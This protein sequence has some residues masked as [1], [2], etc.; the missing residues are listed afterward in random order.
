[1]HVHGLLLPLLKK[2]L[3]RR[4]LV[5]LRNVAFYF[6]FRNLSWSVE[7]SSSLFDFLFF[8]TKWKEKKK[9]WWVFSFDAKGMAVSCPSLESCFLLKNASVSSDN[10]F[11][12]VLSVQ[13]LKEKLSECKGHWLKSKGIFYYYFTTLSSRKM[14]LFL[15]ISGIRIVC[16]H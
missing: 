12:P 6:V 15:L 1:M 16:K 11:L 4:S 14:W 10:L 2:P 8:V 5:L 7:D 9:T 3:H 13:R